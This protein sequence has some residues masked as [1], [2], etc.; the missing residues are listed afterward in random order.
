MFDFLKWREWLRTA[1]KELH[2]T[3]FTAEWKTND[4]H[5]RGTAVEAVGKDR[6]GSFRSFENGFVDYEIMDADTKLWI[7][8]EAMI[9]VSDQNFVSVFQEFSETLRNSN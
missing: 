1:A 8:N 9:R 3:G 7:A 4:E 5:L 2:A 6:L